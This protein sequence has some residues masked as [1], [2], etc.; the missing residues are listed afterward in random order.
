M[1]IWLLTLPEKFKLWYEL[2][3]DLKRS[4]HSENTLLSNTDIPKFAKFGSDGAY[5]FLTKN[6]DTQLYDFLPKSWNL[7]ECFEHYV[8]QEDVWST[9]SIKFEYNY[10]Q[11]MNSPQQR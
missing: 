2:Y 3:G 11:K 5:T 8:Q 4:G 10:Y 6:P 9:E 1:T 7:M